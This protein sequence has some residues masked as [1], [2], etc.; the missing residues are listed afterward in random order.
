MEPMSSAV[1]FTD[2][3]SA[4]KANELIET[5]QRKIRQNE[6]ERNGLDPKNSNVPFVKG[7]MPH[8][9]RLIA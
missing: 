4:A 1:K 5:R 9:S 6:A 2:S 3:R 8:S 7:L